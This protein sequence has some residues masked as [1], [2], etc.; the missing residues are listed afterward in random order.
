MCIQAD[1]SRPQ[2]C[3]T[4]RTDSSNSMLV[5]LKKFQ[6]SH[7]LD[8]LPEDDVPHILGLGWS[9]VSWRRQSPPRAPLRPTL[10]S[11]DQQ[12]FIRKLRKRESPSEEVATVTQPSKMNERGDL[13]TTSSAEVSIL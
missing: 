11:S 5:F 4:F 6:I 1:C 3:Q 13:N 7:D 12:S 8:F 2:S 10:S 9:R